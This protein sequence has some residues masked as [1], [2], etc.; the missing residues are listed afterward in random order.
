MASVGYKKV[1]GILKSSLGSFSDI[2]E[3]IWHK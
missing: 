1:Y 2:T 3:P